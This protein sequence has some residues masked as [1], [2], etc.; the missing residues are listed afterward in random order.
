MANGSQIAFI[1]QGETFVIAA[2]VV[3]PAGV[4][5]V[6]HAKYSGM[7]RGQY[8]VVNSSSTNIVHLAWGNSAAE[9]QSKAVAPIAGNPSE[10][11][12]LLPGAIEILRFPVD[13]YFSGIAA[14]AST[15]YI[16]AGEGI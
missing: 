4:Q 7:A 2:D 11:V 14:G 3:A 12:T 13:A 10:V 9:A 6:T 16:V 8:R 15:V 1:P 5:V